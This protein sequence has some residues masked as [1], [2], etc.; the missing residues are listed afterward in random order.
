MSWSCELL[1]VFGELG[2]WYSM[3]FAAGEPLL[4]SLVSSEQYL[5][6]SNILATITWPAG[7]MLVQVAPNNPANIWPLSCERTVSQP[8]ID[9]QWGYGGMIIARGSRFF[10]KFSSVPLEGETDNAYNIQM[11]TVAL[12][13][14]RLKTRGAAQ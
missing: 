4:M 7:T 9:L 5:Q 6:I 2:K 3:L 1:S 8:D 11:V 13:P 10:L 12:I 14:T